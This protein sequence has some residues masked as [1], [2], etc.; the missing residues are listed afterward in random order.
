MVECG[1]CKKWTHCISTN[2]SPYMLSSLIKGKRKYT[3]KNCTDLT[4]KL[5]KCEELLIRRT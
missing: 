3:C 4:D 5:K 1:N 2:L